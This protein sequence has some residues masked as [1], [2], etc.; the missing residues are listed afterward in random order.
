MPFSLQT[1]EDSRAVRP[2]PVGGLGH[3]GGIRDEE[4]CMTGWTYRLEDDWAVIVPG[5]TWH[6]VVNDGDEVLKLYSLYAPPEHPEGTVHRTKAEADA[7]EAE[8]HH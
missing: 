7:A 1:R 2:H 6:N 8:H 5:G 3:D 4:A